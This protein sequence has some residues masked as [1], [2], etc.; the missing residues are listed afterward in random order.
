MAEGKYK[1]TSSRS[2][3]NSAGEGLKRKRALKT[4]A[5]KVYVDDLKILNY[6]FPCQG[7]RRL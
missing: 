4:G 2:A 7:K 1:A 5:S 6:I 3:P